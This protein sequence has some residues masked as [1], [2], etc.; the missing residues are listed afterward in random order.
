MRVLFAY[1]YI[2]EEDVPYNMKS[3]DL[4]LSDLSNIDAPNANIFD[5]HESANLNSIS[6]IQPAYL[7]DGDENSIQYSM[8][9]ANHNNELAESMLRPLG[10]ADSLQS[11]SKMKENNS[12]I[13][14]PSIIDVVGENSDDFDEEFVSIMDPGVAEFQSVPQSPQDSRYQNNISGTEQN[15][16][17]L[18]AFKAWDEDPTKLPTVEEAISMDTHNFPHLNQLHHHSNNLLNNSA[19]SSSTSLQSSF[20]SLFQKRPA[21]SVNPVSLDSFEN[22]ATRLN[23]DAYERNQFNNNNHDS[24]IVEYDVSEVPPGHPDPSSVLLNDS[25]PY[26]SAKQENTETVNQQQSRMGFGNNT[27][28]IPVLLDG[29]D[30]WDVNFGNQSMIDTLADVNLVDYI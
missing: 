2:T 13:S 10:H 12:L 8:I 21:L 4:D 27:S 11:K 20:P 25:I 6:M 24:G 26:E 18:E 17:V 28:N 1:Q 22:F 5:K 30:E 7:L 9:H 29:F 14:I 15:S 23:G 19:T 16:K 3:E